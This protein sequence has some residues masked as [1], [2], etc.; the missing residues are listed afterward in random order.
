M[1]TIGTPQ[2]EATSPTLFSLY[3]NDIEDSL[4]HSGPYVSDQKINYLMYADD[5]VL[6]AD[7]PSEME[8]ALVA[9]QNIFGERKWKLIPRRQ[10]S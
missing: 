7:N 9:V 2:G 1:T 10:K 8:K 4:T 5:L 3:L 6:L